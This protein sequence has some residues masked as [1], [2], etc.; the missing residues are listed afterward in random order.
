MSDTATAVKIKVGKHAPEGAFLCEAF[1]CNPIPFAR[2]IEALVKERGSDA[3]KSDEVKACL[4]IL[5]AQAYG[6]MGEIDLHDE[7]SRLEKIIEVEGS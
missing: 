1:P 6:Q 4:W 3:I 7:W 2:R 5:N